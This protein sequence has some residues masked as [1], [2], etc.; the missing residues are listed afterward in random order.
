[1]LVTLGNTDFNSLGK[2]GDWVYIASKDDK[3]K[4]LKRIPSGVHYFVTLTEERL[5]SEIGIVKQIENPITA[6]ELA[7]IDYKSRGLNPSEIEDKIIAE[8]E[9]FLQKVNVQPEHTPM[10]VTWLEKILPKKVKEL[11]IHKKFFTGLTK[12]EKENIF[13]I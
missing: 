11:R 5:P 7:Q 13:K 1:M 2:T 10:A 4:G 9:L 6:Q 12:E 8:Y 3:K